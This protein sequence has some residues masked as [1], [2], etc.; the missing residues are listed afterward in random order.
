M[1]TQLPFGLRLVSGT[2]A[3]VALIYGVSAIVAPGLVASLAGLPGVDLPVYQQAGGL[4]LGAAVASY[5]ILRTSR[6]DQVQVAVA[7]LFVN[8]LLSALGAFYY[9][10]LQGVVSIALVGILIYTSYASAAFG[11]YLWAFRETVARPE[12]KGV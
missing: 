8:V 3:V 6:W 7:G 9:V 10:V 2:S 11:Y 4:T 5:L 1:K 12:L